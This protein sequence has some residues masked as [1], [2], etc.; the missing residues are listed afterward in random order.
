MVIE[1]KKLTNNAPPLSMIST[2]DSSAVVALLLL[3]L[4]FQM[5]VVV[6]VEITAIQTGC[7]L[8]KEKRC[9]GCESYCANGYRFMPKSC[10]RS[11]RASAKQCLCKSGLYRKGQSLCVKQCPPPKPK[12]ICYTYTIKSEACPPANLELH[13]ILAIS[14]TNTVTPSKAF[15][16]YEYGN[17]ND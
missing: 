11:C 3:L 5:L 1:K 14:S 6:V 2:G 9:P 13:N 7:G 12:Q 10:P 8:N 16:C 17:W 15:C 4:L